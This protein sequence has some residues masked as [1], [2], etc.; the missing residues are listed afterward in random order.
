MKTE[1]SNPCIRFTQ[2]PCAALLPLLAFVLM[3]VL[4][5]SAASAIRFQFTTHEVVEGAPEI[6]LNVWRT[7]EVATT[8]TADFLTADVTAKAGEDYATTTGSLSFAPGITNQTIRIPI[9]N[10]ALNEPT[11]TF[12]VQLAN[13]S[14]DTTL[15]ALATVTVKVR[16]QLGGPGQL[17]TAFSDAFSVPSWA[18]PLA[19]QNSR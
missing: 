6:V 15:G 5:A 4:P 11:E 2:S 17:W 10:N 16:V 8:L 9:L 3:S 7:G 14:A 18:R 1:A 13:P 12:Q 19:S